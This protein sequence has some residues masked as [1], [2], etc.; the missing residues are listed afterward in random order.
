MP[1]AFSLTQSCT[2][3]ASSSGDVPSSFIPALLLRA[4]KKMRAG[5]RTI[6]VLCCCALL[7]LGVM[8][9]V[10]C[11]PLPWNAD[12]RLAF[13][14][15]DTLRALRKRPMNVA[16][17]REN[18]VLLHTIL[19]RAAVPFWL[20]EGTALGVHREGRLLPWDDDV[21]IGLHHDHL[22][23]FITTAL[24]LLRRCG[25]RVGGVLNGGMFINLVRKDEKVDCDFV[26]PG[27]PCMAMRTTRNRGVP[28][29]DAILPHVRNLQR[30]EF[31]GRMFHI[32]AE[33]YFEVLYGDWRTPR[34]SK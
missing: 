19:N 15:R 1:P 28:T 23:R 22:D 33:P 5:H 26:A 31:L 10:I 27:L 21:D 2:Q 9:L 34:V 25:F 17:C 8:L 3:C 7:T 13:A 14:L 20:S 16:V 18:L 4:V 30:V 6:L 32:P 24:P 29:C 12:R 11:V